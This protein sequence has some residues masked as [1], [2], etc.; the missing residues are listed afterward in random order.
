[1]RW[2]AAPML[3]AAAMSACSGDRASP[4]VLGEAESAVSAAQPVRLALEVDNGVGVPLS[5]RAG[6]TFYLNQRLRPLVRR[7]APSTLLI[8]YSACD[9]DQLRK[10][11]WL[12]ADAVVGG[13][14]KWLGGGDMGLAFM[15]VRPSLA[16]ALTPAYPGWIGHASLL[17]FGDDYVPAEGARRFQQG[18]PAMAPI[19]LSRAGVRF[20]IEAGVENLRARSLELTQRRIDRAGS[21]GL[22]LRTP[23]RP[24]A[25]GGMLCFDVPRRADV[26]GHLADRGID[27]DH[28]PGAGLRVAPHFC[29]R[30][31]EC[32][33]VIDA[34]ADAIP[35]L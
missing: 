33:R 24:E 34:I 4:E 31:D 20:A 15:Y 23:R 8:L 25:R 35:T 6:Q 5:V 3:A 14:H 11:A 27:V 10:L 17:S 2:A 32:D 30:D 22:R 21:R 9:P 13:T 12:E 26:E 19:Y 18:S 7:I 29:H 28:R 16:N 1:M